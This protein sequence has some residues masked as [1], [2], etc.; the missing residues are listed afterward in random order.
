ML[1]L[2]ST[3]PR[4]AMPVR[5]LVAAGDLFGISENSVR[6]TLARLLADRLVARDDRGA[7]RLGPGDSLH[8]LTYPDVDE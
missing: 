5:A 8:H 7:Y 6:V 1:D 3:L 2:L 4:G